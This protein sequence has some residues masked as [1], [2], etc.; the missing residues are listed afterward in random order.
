MICSIGLGKTYISSEKANTYPLKILVVCQKSK[1]NDWCEHFKSLYGYDVYDLTKPKLINNFIV[2]CDKCVAVINYDLIWRRKELLKLK[3]F[4]LVLDESSLINNEV[5]KRAKFILKMIPTNTILLSGSLC[6]GKYERLWSQMN[7]LGWSISKKMYYAQYVDMEISPDGYPII[8]GYKNVDRLKKKMRDH[9]CVFMKS[10]EV[11]NLPTQNFIPVNV[12]ESKEYKKFKKSGIIITKDYELIGD[13]TL[14]KLLY[15]RMLCGHYNADKIKVFKDLIDSTDDRLIVF[16]NFNDELEVLKSAVEDKPI[17]VI[18][19][20]TKD[21]SA[22]EEHSNSITFVQYQ[23]G[24]MGLNLQ[25]ANKIIYFT[26]PLSS[27]LFEQSKKRI[28]RIGQEQPCFYYQLTCGIE[29]RIY[30]MLAMRRDYTDELFAK[31]Y[32]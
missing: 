29:S 13:T 21:L 30:D 17:S 20:K 22:Y 24:A 9:G 25:L 12:P 2:R 31:E 11:L 18:N 27:E 16:Y 4:T 14:T 7:L 1:I 10:E 26:P 28:H 19:G 32:K 5:T 8:T 6:G 15:S 3:D 23:A